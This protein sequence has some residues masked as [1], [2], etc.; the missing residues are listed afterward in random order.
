VFAYEGE[1][2]A[3]VIN[4]NRIKTALCGLLDSSKA[5]GIS[6]YFADPDLDIAKI[7][8]SIG[9]HRLKVIP[10][11]TLPNPH[12][13]IFGTRKMREFI[14][15]LKNRYADRYLIV[16]APPL[17]ESTDAA[18]LSELVDYV[19]LVVPYGRVSKSRL[20]KAI[21]SLPRSKIAGVVLNQ[22]IS[23]V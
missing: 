11:G 13:E 5:P 3:L 1:K 23:Y 7:I 17:E 16:N 20:N 6:D 22:S 9:I 12:L 10:F 18:I 15:V 2:T 19:L 8:H 21:R 14:N 4:C